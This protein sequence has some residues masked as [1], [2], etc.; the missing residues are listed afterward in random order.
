MTTKEYSV[1]EL[2]EEVLHVKQQTFKNSK[3]KYIKKLEQDFNIEIKKKPMIYAL[4]PKEPSSQQKADEEFLEILGCDIGRKDI[5]MIKFLL[6]SILE[7]KIVPVQE[8]LTHWALQKNLIQST[9][10]GVVKNYMEFFNDNNIIVPPMEI[11][12]WDDSEIGNRKCDMETGEIYPTYYKKVAKKIYYDFADNGVGGYRKRLGERAQEAIDT[13]YKTILRERFQKEIVPMIKKRIESSIIDKAKFF[14]R[15]KVLQE[16][17]EAYGLHYCVVIYEPII[18][19]RIQGKLK[20]YFG[21]NK[22]EPHNT[23]IEIDVSHLKVVDVKRPVGTK[24]TEIEK[25]MERHLL[26]KS[27]AQ[28]YKDDKYAMPLSIYNKWHEGKAFEET[29]DGLKS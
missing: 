19:P 27:H 1:L 21:L 9:S 28:L 24:P 22:H 2:C 17:G 29:I 16:V 26:L 7:K 5:E 4:T 14:L 25:M 13:A 3:P 12:V 11:P 20:S 18:N 23:D 6:K 10:R 15:K 8:E